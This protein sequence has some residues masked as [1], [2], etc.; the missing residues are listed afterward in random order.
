MAK[1]MILF[2]LIIDS[3]VVVNNKGNDKDEGKH[4]AEYNCQGNAGVLGFLFILKLYVVSVHE[5]PVVILM[6]D[7]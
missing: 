4:E 6:D 3:N 1:R 5:S 7:G 2:V